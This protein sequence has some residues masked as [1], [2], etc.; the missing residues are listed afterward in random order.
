[1]RRGRPFFLTSIKRRRPRTVLDILLGVPRLPRQ[2]LFVGLSKLR[3]ER[4]K[5]GEPAAKAAWRRGDPSRRVVAVAPEPAAEPETYH[6][7]RLG[8]PRHNK[9]VVDAADLSVNRVNGGE[10]VACAWL[11]RELGSQNAPWPC[12]CKAPA[13]HRPVFCLPKAQDTAVACPG[14]TA[15]RAQ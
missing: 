7:A 2:K 6:F 14:A 15:S 5:K 13:A 11:P 3:P 4:N 8:I 12:T 1:M 10:S 9:A